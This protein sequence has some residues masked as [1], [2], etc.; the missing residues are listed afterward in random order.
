[1]ALALLHLANHGVEVF[2]LDSAAYLW[3]RAGTNCCN[4]PE[5]HA[6]LQALRAVID[7]AAPSVALK[8]EVL[9]PL[10]AVSPYF[11]TDAAAGKECQLAYHSSLRSE[12]HQ[13][14][15]HSLNRNTYSVF[16]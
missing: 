8:A 6:V 16:C 11:G 10:P 7:I 3:K 14:E 13:S 5:A 2:R 15:L 4:L 12:E 9:M 1:M